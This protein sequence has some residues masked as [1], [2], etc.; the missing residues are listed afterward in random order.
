MLRK[1]ESGSSQPCIPPACPIG[2]SRPWS[3]AC[4][5]S[6]LT[7]RG[8]KKSRERHPGWEAEGWCAPH[9][10]IE[11][12]LLWGTKKQRR[13]SREMLILGGDKS[14]RIQPSHPQGNSPKPGRFLGPLLGGAMP[15]LAGALLGKQRWLSTTLGRWGLVT[16]FSF[17]FLFAVYSQLDFDPLVTVI[18]EMHSWGGDDSRLTSQECLHFIKTAWGAQH[19][20]GEQ[21]ADSEMS[22]MHQGDL[23]GRSSPSYNLQIA[24]CG[25]FLPLDWP[26]S[27]ALGLLKSCWS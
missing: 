25:A 16:S 13:P 11:K 12:G 3:S 4:W 9:K 24:V 6:C 14:P 5:Q 2:G 23:R 26:W 10:G 19:Q 8:S 1:K 27:Q 15:L 7:S 20:H 21:T 17:P 22:S 18:W